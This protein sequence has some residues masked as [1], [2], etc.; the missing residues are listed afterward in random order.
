MNFSTTV[1]DVMQLG[2][3]TSQQKI[4]I[5]DYEKHLRPYRHAPL[6]HPVIVLFDNDDGAKSLFAYVKNKGHPNIGLDS[7]DAFHYLGYN[8]YLVKTP[9]LGSGKK[10]CIEDL[11]PPALLKRPVDG[12]TF[13]PNK[14]H[15][16]AGKYGKVVFA[17]QVVI[18]DAAAIDFSGF[19]PL[20]D[21]IVAVIDHHA[22]LRM[23]PPAP[24]PA[25]VA[26]GP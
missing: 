1:H 4:L 2:H 26:A 14:E 11:F 12:K 17:K 23:A 6:A 22:A 16:E 20:L 3:G 8:L 15:D 24:P 5:T 25:A 18:P 10:S 7:T 21:R 19:A 9:E 13:D